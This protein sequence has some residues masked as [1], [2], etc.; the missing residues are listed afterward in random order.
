MIRYLIVLEHHGPGEDLPALRRLL[1]AL[2]RGYGL[3][4]VRVERAPTLPRPAGELTGAGKG[5]EVV[6]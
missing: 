6:P 2:S 3:R 5:P 4:V 1:K